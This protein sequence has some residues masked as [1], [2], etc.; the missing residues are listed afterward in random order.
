MTEK[1]LS[2]ESEIGIP[3]R[4]CGRVVGVCKKVRRSNLHVTASMT[5]TARQQRLASGDGA[6]HR[7]DRSASSDWLHV[8]AL[9][10]LT[11][12]VG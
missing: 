11:A 6:K 3:Q 8:S 7:K 5:E 10:R 1:I 4:C 12:W 9:N 2:S